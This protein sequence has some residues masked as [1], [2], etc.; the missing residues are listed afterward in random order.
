M[1]QTF[2]YLD[3]L[4]GMVFYNETQCIDFALQGQ[5]KKYSS[6]RVG[7][8]LDDMHQAYTHLLEVAE[9]DSTTQL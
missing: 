5:I 6:Q 3:I 7:E 9:L 8:Q 1:T 4:E 2:F